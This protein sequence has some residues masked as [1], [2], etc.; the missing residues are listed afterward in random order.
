MIV[1]STAKVMNIFIA[2]M[3]IAGAGAGCL[4]LTALAA[5]S[6]MAPTRKRGLYVSAL[7][8][9]ILPWCASVLWAQLIAFH[10]NWRYVGALAGGWNGIGLFATLFFYFPPPRVN[11]AGL[12]KREI[13]SRIDFVGGFL[14]IAGLI[15]FLAGLQWGG[16]QY[17]WHTAHVLVPLLLGFA[18]L[19]AFA[20]WE[21][22]GAKY[23]MFP[24]RIKQEPRT[25]GLTLLITFISGAN[26]F[27]VIMM[28]PTAAYNVYG[29]DPVG[30]GLRSLPI[31]FGILTGACVVLC[32]LTLLKGHNK[33][34]MI[35]SSV[36]MTAGCGAL[37]VAR[38]DNLH[39]LWGILTIAGLGIGGIVVPASIMTT[40]IC[41]DV[42]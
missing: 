42:S 38:V 13:I 24:S 28:W 12:S 6:E 34:L 15:L 3:A 10:S 18:L 26:F 37:A 27:S 22:L 23:P 25:L 32:L 30:V 40:V 17:E 36:L 19:V 7:V 21:W 2:G 16:Y 20:L 11:S 29:H 8:F 31:G 9:T 41:P 35:G 14:S 33:A 4:E 1:C 5:T 39:Q